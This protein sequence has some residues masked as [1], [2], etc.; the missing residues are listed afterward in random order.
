MRR[1]A[2]VTGG[3]GFLGGY[4]VRDLLE[5]GFDQVVVLMRGKSEDDCARRLRALWWERA[6]LRD[7]VGDRVTV[8]CGDITMERLG[9]EPAAYD[10][11]ARSVTHIVHAAA[12]IGVNETAER[13]G[14]V[15]VD[16]AF[17]VLALA[18]EAVRAGSL[19]R[20]VHVSTAYVAGAREGRVLE[21]D[22]VDSGFNSLYEQ[23]KFGAEQ[24]VRDA[25]DFVPACI[26]RP[27]QIVGDSESG[28]VATFNTLYYPLK[29]Y[30]K[31]Q[32]P[33]LPVSAGQK[34]NMVPVDYVSRMAVRALLEPGAQ[35]TTYHAVIPTDSQPTA[36]ELLS[37]VR[38]WA[39]DNLRFDPGKP[40]FLP[41]LGAQAA[42]RKRNMAASDA[43]KRKSPL[44]NMLA[45]APYFRERRTYD[46]ANA[47][48]LL[49]RDFPAWRD[50]MPRLLEY[51]ARKGFLN[52]TGRTVFE[53][54]LVRLGGSRNTVTY[55]DV[56]REGMSRLEGAE[57]RES[58]LRLAS[59]LSARGIGEG[60][61]VVL[62]GVNSTRY[63]IADAATG[64]VGATSVPLYYTS[65]VDDIV[66]L[67]R[68]SGAKLAFIGTEK[69]LG[70]LPGHMDIPLVSLLDGEHEGVVGWG[71]FLAGAGEAHDIVPP[72][73]GD[74]ATIRYTSGTT[75]DPKGVTFTQSQLRWMGEVMP[76][77]LDWRTRN[78]KLRYLS[79]LPMSHVVEGILVAY[80]P[81]FILSDIEMYFL[82]DFDALT[83]ALP[84]V[85]PTL[86]FSVPR[87]YEKVWDQFESSGIGQ[88]FLAM[89]EGPAKRALARVARVGLL[90]KAGLDQCRQL[91]VGSAAVSMDLLENYRSLGI[92][93]HNAYGVTE[94]PLIALSRLGENELGSVGAL[95][96]ETTAEINDEGEIMISGPQVTAGY[97]GRGSCLNE[98]GFFETGD[99]GKWSKRGNLVIEGRKKELVITS[100][101]KN[102]S[103]EK[104][105]T[106]LKGIPG[107]SEALLVGDARPYVC[108]LLWLEDDAREGFDPAALDTAVLACNMR[109]SH[110]EQVKRWAV[111]DG[112][113]SIAEGELTPNLKLRRR[114][115]TEVNG[116]TID[117][118]YGNDY[119]GAAGAL[120][121]GAQR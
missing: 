12:E 67:S 48:A 32:L 102:V 57:A 90:R 34:M 103:P 18:G 30:L 27:A 56:S 120:H 11:L 16:G 51:A 39:V 74:V 97:D 116:T 95:L 100:Y 117:A 107:V 10:E 61:R 50:Y 72:S 68:K 58:I 69:L 105:E 5:E 55:Y 3:S 84:K 42:G 40:V 85:R 81:Y 119:A 22:L 82:R 41:V 64:L 53:Q 87:F 70:E 24:L 38:E 96:P 118:L 63:L 113:L 26:V 79:F 92:E 89:E 109:L 9:L 71:D 2:L 20:L 25:A 37:F 121:V 17:N 114:R 45:L 77:V 94:A 1:C 62:A 78:G 21:G 13:F 15:N 101:G 8:A 73:P 86:F 66:S 43:P 108:A 52:H 93:I 19:Q 28:F 83:E 4:V 29:L 49:G 54:M 44:Q 88:R 33:V 65:P 31:G 7:A 60:D 76:A 59:A 35:G 23:S 115:V 6:E 98:R 106:L 110:P 112:R 99:L 46:T 14:K 111:M 104:V 80:A 75:G 91:I 47:E 36:G